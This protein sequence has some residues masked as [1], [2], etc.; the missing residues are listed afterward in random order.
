MGTCQM[1]NE[2]CLAKLS[3]TNL[4]ESSPSRRLASLAAVV[5]LLAFSLLLNAALHWPL[6]LHLDE[7]R[8][9]AAFHSGHVWCFDHIYRMFMGREPWTSFSQRLGY[10]LGADLRLIAWVP[11]LLAIPLRSFLGPLGSYNLLL[12]ASPGLAALAAWFLLRQVTGAGPWT[13][14]GPALAYAFCPY[15][16]AS[17]SNGQVAKFNHWTLPLYLAALHVALRTR[18]PL[19]GYLLLALATLALAFT[20]PSTALFVPLAALGWVLLHAL[21]GR[22][23]STPPVG[24]KIPPIAHLSSMRVLARGALCLAVTALFLLIPWQYYRGTG[25]NGRTVGFTPGPNLPEGEIPFSAPMAQLDDLL[26]GL[27][28]RE[29]N[30]VLTTHVAYLGIPLLLAF[31]LFSLRPYKGRWLAVALVLTGAVVSLGPKLSLGYQYVLIGGYNLALPVKYLE[32]LGYPLDEGG[33]YYRAV[34]LASMGLALGLAG[35]SAR[36]KRPWA[37]I[38]AWTIGLVSVADGIWTTRVLWPKPLERVEGMPALLAMA[39]DPV[40]GAV[41]DLPL[42]ASTFANEQALL[43]A[44]FH[45][46][47][48]V[49]IPVTTAMDNTANLQRLEPVLERVLA[50]ADPT[51][52]KDVLAAAGFRYVIWRPYL[53]EYGS[54]EDLLLKALGTPS[55]SGDLRYWEL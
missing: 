32:R 31:L 27:G 20:S 6:P 14:T 43:G 5:V 26:L 49:A 42:E 55:I 23:F 40:P 46:R 48:S 51:A 24:R 36:F 18:R 38:F 2:P 11:A 22:S 30:P 35:A 21:P 33:M 13:S 10:P 19:R 8:V 50:S 25:S 34:L 12:L 4:Q 7:Y 1:A 3:G 53:R 41:L 45:Q 37:W 44:V 15:A 16:L 17:M 28:H 54:F 9:S 47:A 39:E 29:A 52:A